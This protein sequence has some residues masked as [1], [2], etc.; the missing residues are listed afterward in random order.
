MSS[1]TGPTPPPPPMYPVASSPVSPE[2]GGP[3]LSEPQRLVNT[4]IA[5]SKTFTDI[6]R[7]ASWWVPFLLISIFSISF[8]VMIDKKVG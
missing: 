8:F 4:F 2:P 1:P 6:R 3:G 7:N 5:P